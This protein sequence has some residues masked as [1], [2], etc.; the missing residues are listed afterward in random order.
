MMNEMMD[1]EVTDRVGP[2]HA[3]LPGRTAVRHAAAFGSVVLGGRRV[4]VNRPRARTVDGGEVQLG[5]YA[6]FANDD[7]LT[8]VVM[9]R[10]LAG[11]ATRPAPGR[12][13]TRR[14]ASEGH[15]VIDVALRGEPPVQGGDHQGGGRADG[16][17]PPRSAGGSDD[18]RGLLR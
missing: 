13:W 7:Q 12:R 2:K 11:V 17:R 6:T 5:T 3:K 15:G 14:Q 4:P 9:E 10:M 1:A 18:R 16:P 8:E